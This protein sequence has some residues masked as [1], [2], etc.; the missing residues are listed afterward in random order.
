MKIT[1]SKGGSKERKVELSKIVIPDLWHIAQGQGKEWSPEG[2]E[3]AKKE[4]LECWHLCHDLKRHI[5][6]SK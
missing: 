6:D 1:L 3:I 2:A 5:E 4:I